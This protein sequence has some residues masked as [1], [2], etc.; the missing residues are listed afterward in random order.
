MT[1]QRMPS[2]LTHAAVF[3]G[4]ERFLHA[5]RVEKIKRAARMATAL[6]STKGAH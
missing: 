3:L 6:R 2:A 4:R 5:V 1:N